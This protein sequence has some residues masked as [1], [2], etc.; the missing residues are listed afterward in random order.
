MPSH[1]N[2]GVIIMRQLQQLR[3]PP[4][5]RAAGWVSCSP[6]RGDIAA[7]GRGDGLDAVAVRSV[8][9]HADVAAWL[10]GP[11]DRALLIDA[12]IASDGGACG[13]G[14]G[15]KATFTP[16]DGSKVALLPPTSPVPE[17]LTDA[18]LAEVLSR[19]LRPTRVTLAE[20]DPGW[21]VRF[22][23]RA[24]QLRAAL[25]ERVLRL[26]HHG[27]TSVPGLVAKPIVD[28]MLCVADPEDE[29]AYLPDVEA[30]GYE[31]GVR[32]PGH[33]CLRAGEP[34]ERINLHVWA[35][36][37]PEVRRVLLLRDHL[38]AHA[39][40]RERYA[41]VKRELAGREWRDINYYAEAKSPVINEILR[42]A[43][44]TDPP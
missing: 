25:G 13:L 2:V 3:R 7:I 44:W 16:G 39:A 4:R 42:R 18:Y 40:E 15:S 20:P 24:A 35:P 19:P 9:D 41:A 29:P 10:D 37:D 21:D 36:D 23:E 34:D 43:G 17:P 26:E 8:G 33:L 22:A 32:E 31:V 5:R 38:R 27:S 11:R 12:K 6:A 1:F 30:L 28:I 14:D